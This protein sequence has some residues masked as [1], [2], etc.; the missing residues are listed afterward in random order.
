[1]KQANNTCSWGRRG[2]I[3]WHGLELNVC[4]AIPHYPPNTGMGHIQRNSTT[5]QWPI[6]QSHSPHHFSQQPVSTWYKNC[7]W[8]LG[9]PP[10]SRYVVWNNILG[11]PCKLNCKFWMAQLS[12]PINTTYWFRTDAVHKHGYLWM[13]KDTK[14]ILLLCCRYTN[15]GKGKKI[16]THPLQLTTADKRRS[17]GRITCMEHSEVSV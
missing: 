1:M 12:T 8:M 4:V 17:G 9:V 7:V 13:Q 16:K 14:S 2:V 10:S 3:G 11:V 15:K 5:K 6:T